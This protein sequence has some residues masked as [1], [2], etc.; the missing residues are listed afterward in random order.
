MAGKT[1]NNTA[2]QAA[3]FTKP[4]TETWPQVIPNTHDS[5]LSRL[6]MSPLHEKKKKKNSPLQTKP[7]WRM[8]GIDDVY[9]V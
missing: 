1:E 8:H 2:L 5:R 3:K 9:S 6:A 4:G 7:T